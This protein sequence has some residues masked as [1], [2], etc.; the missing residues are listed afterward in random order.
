[1]YVLICYSKYA[2]SLVVARLHSRVN[3]YSTDVA[4]VLAAKST[5]EHSNLDDP[6]TVCNLAYDEGFANMIQQSGRRRKRDESNFD[7]R[8]LFARGHGNLRNKRGRRGGKGGRGRGN[9]SLAT[10]QM[11]SADRLTD[12][13]PSTF[14]DVTPRNDKDT[15][16]ADTPVKKP[17]AP[18]PRVTRRQIRLSGASDTQG[19]DTQAAS[20]QAGLQEASSLKSHADSDVTAE[21]NDHSVSKASISTYETRSNPKLTHRPPF[22]KPKNMQR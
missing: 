7:E 18:S 15:E 2:S 22:F 13:T 8:G 6:P 16:M 3:L 14:E 12:H 5:A 17:K 11:D 1:M 9:K 21:D 19:T 4:P 20:V 10:E